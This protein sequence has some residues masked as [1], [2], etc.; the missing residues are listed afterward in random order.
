MSI[1]F[2]KFKPLKCPDLG[3][4]RA[5]ACTLGDQL[6]HSGSNFFTGVV[7]GR[8]LS[9]GD[10]GSFSLGLSLLVFSL[11]FQDNL[12]AT[13]Y[14]YH[15]YKA[16]GE[17]RRGLRAGALVQSLMLAVVCG[18][19][20]ISVSSLPFF[21][22]R[23]EDL[24]PIF[25][26]L[27]LSLPLMFLREC[28]RR[29][30]FAEFHMAHALKLDLSVSALQFS[31]LFIIWFTGWLEPYA[32]FA[33]MSLAA[34]LGVAA[35][36]FIMRRQFDFRAMSVAAD[37]RANIVFGRWL[38][39]GS[40]CHLGSLYSYPW[41]VY[42]MHG[43]TEAGAFAACFSLINLLNPFIL[44]FNNYF[45]PKIIQT[46]MESGVT[47]MHKLIMRA[48]LLFVPMAGGIVLFLAIA[49]GWLVR[50]VYG[51]DFSGLGMAVG[52]I[53]IAIAPTIVSAPL[54][55]GIL[56]LNKPQLNPVF[57]IVALIVTAVAGM[58]LAVLYGTIGAAWGF[59]LSTSCACAALAYLYRREIRRKHKIHLPRAGEEAPDHD[60]I[61]EM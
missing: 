34:G 8:L 54:Q 7:V 53:S 6:V 35:G 17:R 15:L 38:L 19:L 56:A 20:L 48:C 49:G 55:L 24:P 39:A 41:M 10:F 36:A 3:Q 27:A 29:Q 5:M 25:F 46:Y 33:A 58:P 40:F 42:M 60:I 59:V 12:L 51:E 14:T 30:F 11:V 22:E 13:P 1:F 45:R 43:K 9:I 2:N 57:H 26:A 47:A 16:D 32:V 50:L 18:A 28:L 52:I 61:Q 4:F 31:F 21:A 44:G 23:G 37:T